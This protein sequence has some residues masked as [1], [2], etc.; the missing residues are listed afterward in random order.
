M[1]LDWL[2]ND[3]NSKYQKANRPTVVILPGLT[4]SSHESY[5][6]HLAQQTLTLGYRCVV[7]NYRGFGGA[8]LKVHTV[9]R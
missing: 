5:V 4:G 8:E 9:L 1:A 2:H 7:F 6:R 3:K